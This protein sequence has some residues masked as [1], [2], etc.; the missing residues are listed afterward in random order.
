MWQNFQMLQCFQ[1]LQILLRPKECY[2]LSNVV[3]IAEFSRMLRMLLG[4]KKKKN[5]LQCSRSYNLLRM[6]QS[7][8]QKRG[9]P[10]VAKSLKN[11]AN[12]AQPTKIV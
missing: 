8:L 1:M 9:L 7:C 11:V 4:L 5:L 10:N 2:K 6:G 12:D 3:D